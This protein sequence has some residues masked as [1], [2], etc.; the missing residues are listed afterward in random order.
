[1]PGDKYDDGEYEK[2]YTVCHRIP[3][4]TKQRISVSM[5]LVVAKVSPP[6]TF[7]LNLEIHEI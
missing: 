4:I 3:Q 5:V 7:L 6:T 1:M 2:N